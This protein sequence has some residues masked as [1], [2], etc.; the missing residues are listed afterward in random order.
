VTESVR[1]L[2]SV[3]S[4]SPAARLL[5]FPHAGGGAS[6]CRPW[7]AAAGDTVELLAVQAPGREDRAGEPPAESVEQLAA[8]VAAELPRWADRPLALFGHSFGALVAYE[9][10]RL[11]EQHGDLRPS[12]LVVAGAGAPFE[13]PRMAA[14]AELDDDALGAELARRGALPEGVRRVPR[15]LAFVLAPVR[16]DLA[17]VGRYRPDP[18]PPVGCPVRALAGAADPEAPPGAVSRW[19]E[20]ADGPFDERTFPGGHFFVTEHRDEVIADVESAALAASTPR[21]RQ[22][23]SRAAGA[24]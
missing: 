20:L 1:S 11:L 24:G 6:V 23:S 19:R 4:E 5:C 8:E 9:V 7:A 12:L 3:D 10:A 21:D 13:V 14:L 16:A 2:G 17:A 18:E 22:A 15:L